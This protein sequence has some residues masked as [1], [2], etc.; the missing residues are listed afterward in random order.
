MRKQTLISIS[1]ATAEWHV[2]GVER[3]RTVIELSDIQTQPAPGLFEVPE[4]T[5]RSRP[6]RFA[7]SLT[8]LPKRPRTSQGRC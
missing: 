1:G 2:R 5:I 4:G 3:I 7:T 8:L 6:I